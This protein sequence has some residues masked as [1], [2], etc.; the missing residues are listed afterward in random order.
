MQ[1]RSTLRDVAALAGVSV[2]TASR[3][4]NG[5][6]NVVPHKVAAVMDAVRLLDYQTDVGARRL[7]SNDGRNRAIAAV[8]EDLANPFCAEV[9]RAI[10]DVARSEGV[11]VL[12]GSV[13]DD[14]DRERTLLREF[15]N[16][17]ADGMLL[18]SAGPDHRFVRQ[19]VGAGMPIV[20]VDRP[21]SGLDADT[22]I[23]DNREAS[24]AAIHHLADHGHRRIAVLGERLTRATN[25]DRYEGFRQA[26]AE[27]GLRVPAEYVAHDLRTPQRVDDAVERMLALPDPPTAI[28]SGQNDIAVATVRALQRRGMEHRTAL[29]GFDDFPLA[30]LLRPRVTVVAQDPT[31]MGRLATEILFR[32]LA[33]DDGPAE[34]RVI[35]TRLLA[36]G[37]GE[38][39]PES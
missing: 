22:V 34:Y 4:M 23:V 1:R 13:D 24:R 3:V 6:A 21:P 30:D 19:S 15:A 12:A 25:R 10:E 38:I 35:P 33:G 2:T 8:L 36:R 32:R 26:T 17:R 31:A 29:V 11:L 20:F 16:R 9:L 14:I 27:I 18:M 37:S 7:R 39:P 5:Q 28:F